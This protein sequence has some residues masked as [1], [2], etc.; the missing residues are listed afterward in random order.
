VNLQP[1]F[2]SLNQV[3]RLHKGQIDLFGG[4]HDVRDQ[5]LLE[6]ALAQPETGFG[7]VWKCTC[8]FER[9]RII[10]P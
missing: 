10:L 8:L 4:S 9:E 2:L 1:K 7:N 5:G 6:S 3:L